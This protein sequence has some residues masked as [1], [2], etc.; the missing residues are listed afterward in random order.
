[1]IQFNSTDE[2]QSLT[3]INQEYNQIFKPNFDLKYINL[4]KK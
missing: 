2:T 3:I 1:M 4:Y